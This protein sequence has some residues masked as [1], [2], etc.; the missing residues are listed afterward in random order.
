MLVP[1]DDS[2]EC[3]GWTQTNAGGKPVPLHVRADGDSIRY[4]T[5]GGKLVGNIVAHYSTKGADSVLHRRTEATR[6]P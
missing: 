3:H 5:Q 4:H 1:L 2:C 6:A